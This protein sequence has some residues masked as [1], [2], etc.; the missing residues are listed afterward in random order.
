MSLSAPRAAALRLSVLVVAACASAASAQPTV[1]TDATFAP[2]DWSHLSV[3]F[4]PNGGSGYIAQAPEGRTGTGLFI[5]NSANSNNSGAWNAAIYQGFTYIP[6]ISGPLSE[7]AFSVDT[8]FV[9]GLQAVSFIVAQSGFAWRVGYFINTAA[10]TTYSVIASPAE[11]SPLTL[12]QPALPDFSA[13]GAPIRFG[14]TSGNSSSPGGFGYSRLGVYDNFG[15][16]FV[17]APGAA[18]ALALAGLAAARRS[19]R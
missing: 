18:A 2:G 11:I 1:I 7:L 19:R 4:G 16:S 9:D 17:P 3:P 10:W 12:G 14:F 6:A 5:S 15:V 13:A 8:R